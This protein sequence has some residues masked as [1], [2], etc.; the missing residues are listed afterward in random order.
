MS[1]LALAAI[2]LNTITVILQWRLA[3]MTDDQAKKE[4]CMLWAMASVFMIGLLF[5]I[6]LK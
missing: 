3:R 1:L 5:G 6:S 2:V 4:H